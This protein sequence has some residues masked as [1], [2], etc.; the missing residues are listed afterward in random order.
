MLSPILLTHIDT[1]TPGNEKK[2]KNYPQNSQTIIDA[3]LRTDNIYTQPVKAS[4]T[5]TNIKNNLL[6]YIFRKKKC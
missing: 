2:I 6:I 1:D 3:N 5:A 4:Y